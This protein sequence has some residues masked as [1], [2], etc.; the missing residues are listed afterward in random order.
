MSSLASLPWL[1]RFAQFAHLGRYYTVFDVGQE[2]VGFAQARDAQRF[3][4]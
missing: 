4:G 1:I 2:R 3:L